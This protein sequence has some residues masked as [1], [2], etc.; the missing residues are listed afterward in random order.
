[1]KRKIEEK[2]LKWKN[3]TDRKPL[4]LNG[5]RQVGKTYILRDFGKRFYKNTVYINLESNAGAR[6]Y[7]NDNISAAKLIKYFEG[8]SKKNHSRRDSCYFR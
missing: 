1:M 3:S 8:E 4:I 7:F 2:L 6:S 5:A